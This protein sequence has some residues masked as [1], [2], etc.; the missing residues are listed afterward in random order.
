[1]IKNLLTL[2]ILLFSVQAIAGDIYQC[3]EKK[4]DVLEIEASVREV[5]IDNCLIKT[6]VIKNNPILSIQLRESSVSSLEISSSHLQDF[7]ID[8]KSNISSINVKKSRFVNNKWPREIYSKLTID[9][10]TYGIAKSVKEAKSLGVKIDGLTNKTYLYDEKSNTCINSI[11]E[12][13]YNDDLAECSYI[14]G[15]LIERTE[16]IFKANVVN[17]KKA[18]TTL[19]SGEGVNFNGGNLPILHFTD[20]YFY[21]LKFKGV[22]TEKLKFQDSK[23]EQA[24]ISSSLLNNVEILNTTVA[25]SDVVSSNFNSCVVSNAQMIDLYTADTTFTNCQIL[26]SFL[27]IYNGKNTE[28]TGGSLRGSKLMVKLPKLLKLN[29]VDL[30]GTDLSAFSYEQLRESCDK[31]LVDHTT[32]FPT[33]SPKLNQLPKE[34]FKQ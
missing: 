5:A 2:F 11:G 12:K 29:K 13:G 4:I 8:P 1:M 24:R 27:Q 21:G 20:N 6:L 7:N 25:N 33:G 30:R 18:S 31:C 3:F 34:E 32:L 22:T 28:F 23:L 9:L 26:D 10:K 16:S 19:L 15:N 14:Q 17:L